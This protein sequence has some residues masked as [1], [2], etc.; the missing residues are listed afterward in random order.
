MNRREFLRPR[1]LAE[2]AGQVLGALQEL[3]EAAYPAAPVVGEVAYLRLARRAM[4][5]T[6]ALL[7]PFDTADAESI[8]AAVFD[9]IDD[10]E[11]QLTVYRDTSEVCRL[12]RLA[13]TRPVPVEAGLFELLSKAAALTAETEGAFDV[14]AGALVKAWGFFRGPKRVPPPEELAQVR[15]RVGMR[16]VVLS[17]APVSPTRQRGTPVSPT[18]QRGTPQP[19]AP[20]KDRTVRYLRPGVEINLGAIG[21]GYALDRAAALLEEWG[22]VPAALLHGGYSSVYARGYPPGDER[23]WQVGIRHPG[24]LGRRL[25]CVWLR[26]RA[27][28]NSAATF[29]HL[30]YNGRKLGH[31]LD[32]RSGWPAAGMASASVLAPTAAEADAL[33]TAFFVGGLDLGRRYCDTHPGIGAILLPEGE[34]AAPVV[35]G[36]EAHE[37]S[38]TLDT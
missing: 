31:V 37:F 36:L 17:P 33:S 11:A 28:G 8:G 38:L 12:N 14:A 34:G 30:E 18:C 27:L 3:Q 5:T 21:K 4:A 16:H 7:L 24:D 13:P 6:F 20:A 25:A 15:E 29:Q 32:P 2:S 9:L 23:G 10:L 26:D 19:D 22:H 1:R 35:L